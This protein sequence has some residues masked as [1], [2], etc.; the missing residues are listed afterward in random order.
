MEV[1]RSIEIKNAVLRMG[2]NGKTYAE[3]RAIYPIPK[4]TLSYW[5]K[6]HDQPR[7][8]TRQLELLKKARLRGVAVIRENKIKRLAEAKSRAA[9][10]AAAF[11]FG[12]T[13][14]IKAILAMLYWAE[15]SKNDNGALTF[16]NTDPVLSQFYLTLLRAVF[17]LDESRLRIRLHLHH[18]HKKRATRAFWSELL[19]VPE[20]QFGKIYVK[21]RSTRKRFRRNFQ[22]ICFIVYGDSSIRRELLALGVLLAQKFE[23]S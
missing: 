1:R 17:P 23:P 10:R 9:V 8:R 19:Q 2:M 13:S 16:A 22:G 6:N 15:G 18:Y 21:K 11:D 3:I 14:S 7:D 5:F 12:D 4:S 20:S